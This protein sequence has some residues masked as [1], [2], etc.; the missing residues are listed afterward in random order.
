MARKPMTNLPVQTANQSGAR[1]FQAASNNSGALPGS[2]F[3][4]QRSA[5]KQ[6]PGNKSVG[7]KPG[8]KSSS[9]EDLS[10]RINAPILSEARIEGYRNRITKLSREAGADQIIDEYEMILGEALQHND[11]FAEETMKND[12][13]QFMLEHG[14]GRGNA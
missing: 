3:M 13:D 4:N 12:R 11:S 2:T 10:L 6:F 9:G 8:Q 5:R 14:M 1:A 7:V